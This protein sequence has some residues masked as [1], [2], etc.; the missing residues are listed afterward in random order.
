MFLDE[1]AQSVERRTNGQLRIEVYSNN[2]L[3]NE[4]DTAEAL[5]EGLLEV[6][7]DSELRERLTRNGRAYVEANHDRR[8]IAARLSEV[9]LRMVLG[10]EAPQ[11][12][13][14]ARKPSV[15][16]A[17]HHRER[18]DTLEPSTLS[19][20]GGNGG[21]SAEEPVTAPSDT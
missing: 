12:V 2:Q 3:A 7:S 19:A 16:P 1:A 5:A 11:T 13:R 9:Y 4:T 10:G 18:F 17:P 15:A 21:V 20:A 14:P 6:L 8:L